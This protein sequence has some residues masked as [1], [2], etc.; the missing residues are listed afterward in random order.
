MSRFALIQLVPF[1]LASC[2]SAALRTRSAQKSRCR[3][4]KKCNTL[5]LMNK[6]WKMRYRV[7]RN[8]LLFVPQ[9]PFRRAEWR[10]CALRPWEE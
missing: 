8:S 7:A 6:E 10:G 1:F 5:P 9:L 3:G 2:Q 4:K